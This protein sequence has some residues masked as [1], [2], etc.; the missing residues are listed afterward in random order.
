MR[1][2]MTTLLEL[3]GIGLIAWGAAMIAVPAGLIVAGVGCVAV[4]YLAG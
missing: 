1:Q 3:V 4:G 2:A